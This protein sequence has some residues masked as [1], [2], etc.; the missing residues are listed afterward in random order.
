MGA[1]SVKAKGAELWNKLIND[2]TTVP[3]TKQ[4]RKKYKESLLPYNIVS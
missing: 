1:N 4:F 3:N 2:I